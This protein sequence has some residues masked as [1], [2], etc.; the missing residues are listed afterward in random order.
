VDTSGACAARTGA[1]RAVT[2]PDA[3]THA[4][5]NTHA[6]PVPDAAT[7]AAVEL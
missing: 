1:A 5:A 3:D 4:D 7:T 6:V 2:Q